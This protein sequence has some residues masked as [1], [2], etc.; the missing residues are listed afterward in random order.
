L[1]AEWFVAWLI[2]LACLVGLNLANARGN[3]ELAF[4]LLR[5]LTSRAR[6]RTV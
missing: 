1:G 2:A 6:T 3:R 4:A 5:S